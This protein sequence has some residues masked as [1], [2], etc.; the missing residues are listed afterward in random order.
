MKRQVIVITHKEL[1]KEERKKY[2][3]EHP[4]YRLSIPLRYPD[5]PIYVSIIAI[6]IE[7]LALLLTLILLLQK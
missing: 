6:G 3:K 4:G 1:S 7:L 5:F 2:A